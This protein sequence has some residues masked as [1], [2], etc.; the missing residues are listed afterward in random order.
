VR[1]RHGHRTQ[2]AAGS[3]GCRGGFAEGIENPAPAR[4]SD[5]V[6]PLVPV[7]VV[8]VL[9]GA[10]PAGARSLE[11]SV[12]EAGTRRPVPGATV[13]VSSGPTSVEVQTDD[14]GTFVL[15]L[16]DDARGAVVVA[17]D[18]SG[19]APLAESVT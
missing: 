6:R 10:V 18:T 19:Y 8:F 2:E 12:R 15:P 17:V 13:V 5:A 11:G 7:L 3:P 1:I 4:K 16:A 9:L 14:Q